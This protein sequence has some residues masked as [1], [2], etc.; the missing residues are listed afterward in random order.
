MRNDSITKLSNNQ[1]EVLKLI[2][3]NPQTAITSFIGD[4]G[5]LAAA[6]ELAREKLITF[7]LDGQSPQSSKTEYLRNFV[8][9]ATEAEITDTGRDIMSRNGIET[10]GGEMGGEDLGMDDMG[11]DTEGGEEELPTEENPFESF[12]SFLNQKL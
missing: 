3:N 10:A 5:L 8:R 12:S 1:S 4:V 2:D 9:N 6:V 11:G 7:S